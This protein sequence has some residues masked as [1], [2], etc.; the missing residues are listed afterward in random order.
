MHKIMTIGLLEFFYAIYLISG[1][2]KGFLIAY[3]IH[4]FIDITLLSSIFLIIFMLIALY[5]SLELP[6][7]YIIAILL[8]FLFYLWMF[9]TSTYTSSDNYWIYKIIYFQTNILAFIFPVLLYKYFNINLFFKYFIILTTALNI[10]FMIFIFPY[11][12]TIPEFYEIGQSYLF[13]SLYSGFNILLLL[14]SKIKY[15]F[16]FLT[17]FLVIANFYTL[18]TSSG[19]GGI[20]FTFALLILYLILYLLSKIN[21]VRSLQIS[22]KKTFQHFIFL[23]VFS[24]A[25]LIYFNINNNTSEVKKVQLLER[26]LMRLNLLVEATSGDEVGASVN[27]RLE[28]INFSLSK[29]FEDVPHYFFGYGVGSFSMEYTNVDKKDYPHNII[30]EIL[31]EFGLIGFFLFLLFYIYIV[32]NYRNTTLIWLVALMTLH[33][34]KSSGLTDLR[35]LFATLALVLISCSKE[36]DLV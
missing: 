20:I 15:K 26:T 22:K 34:L 36:K 17:L 8:L 18:I 25:S 28:Q 16:S 32:K 7:Q 24:T 31:F 9:A 12:Y 27:Y 29:I 23:I 21:K 11:I 13:V 10:Y 35:L 2:I 5:K 19:R 33:S 30:L 14:I 3:N 6:K 4:P 1:F